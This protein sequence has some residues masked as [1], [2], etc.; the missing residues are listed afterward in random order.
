[1]HRERNFAQHRHL[2]GDGSGRRRVPGH[3]DDS[4]PDE[5]HHRREHLASV[6]DPRRYLV[7]LRRLMDL[8]LEELEAVVRAF[9][10]HSERN[11][12]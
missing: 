2:L 11:A 3:R 4:R 7:L 6:E 1:M 10:E 9:N 5:A 12:D 8:S